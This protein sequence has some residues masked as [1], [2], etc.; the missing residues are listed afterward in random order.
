MY[1]VNLPE[2]VYTVL[3][4]PTPLRRLANACLRRLVPPVLDRGGAKV[5]LN[6]LDPV[7]SGALTLGVYEND[8]IAF[9]RQHFRK[10]MTFVD[11]GANVGLYTALALRGEAGRVL[12]VEPHKETFAYLGKT[13]AANFPRC[14]VALENLAVGAA[15]GEM[16][17]WSNPNNKGDNRLYADPMLADSQPTQVETLDALCLRQGIAA[18]DFLKIDV[19]GAELLVLEGAQKI[20]RASRQ[21]IVMAEFWPEGIR[22]CGGDPGRYFELFSSAGIELK[23]MVGRHLREVDPTRLIRETRGRCYRN[24]VGFGV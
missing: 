9:F 7:V 3:L 17:L 16:V 11:V 2:F 21:C 6:P 20:L 18:V 10:G 15:T 5:V 19:Q 14:P 22:R 4:R 13:V 12:A 23:E 8:E 1:P 24:L